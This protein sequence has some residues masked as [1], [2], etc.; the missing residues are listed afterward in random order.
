MTAPAHLAP[1]QPG[2]LALDRDDVVW[3]VERIEKDPDPV[4]AADIEITTWTAV[5]TDGLETRRIPAAALRP[6]RLY[7]AQE[8]AAMY[9]GAQLPQEKPL[10]PYL[11]RALGDIA[12]GRAEVRLTSDQRAGE[13]LRYD[14]EDIVDPETGR[15]MFYPGVGEF[16][17]RGLIDER[18]APTDR[19]WAVLRGEVDG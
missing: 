8:V 7:S 4:V 5:V 14:G 1:I 15:R 3:R 12:Y 9:L 18:C 13:I 16:F 11:L 6:A 2:E 17:R 19:G 10:T